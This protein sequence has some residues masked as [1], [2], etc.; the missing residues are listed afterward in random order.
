[1][2]SASQMRQPTHS[3]FADFLLRNPKP[4]YTMD[5][6][7][8]REMILMARQL[9]ST[10]GVQQEDFLSFESRQKIALKRIKQNLSNCAGALKQGVLSISYDQGRTQIK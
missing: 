2:Q 8:D 7:Y 9:L 1:M 6:S 4:G 3:R 5:F 10:E